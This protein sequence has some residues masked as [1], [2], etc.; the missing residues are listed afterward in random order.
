[1][2]RSTLLILAL[3]VG[4]LQAAT[5]TSWPMFRGDPA[6]SGVSPAR[7]PEA[8]VLKWRFKTGGAVSATA[9]IVTRMGKPTR[10]WCGSAPPAMLKT[11]FEIAFM[12]TDMKVGKRAPF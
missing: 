9:A 2:L 1:M 6:Q 3:A 8:P 11:L 12:N 5:A 7:I 4:G 10:I